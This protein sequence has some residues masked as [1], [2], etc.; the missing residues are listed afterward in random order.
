MRYK[1]RFEVKTAWG[2][3]NCHARLDIG[4]AP[5]G[6]QKYC[7]VAAWRSTPWGPRNAATLATQPNSRTSSSWYSLIVSSQISYDPSAIL[8]VVRPQWLVDSKIWFP[9]LRLRL[10]GSQRVNSHKLC[11]EDAA[12]LYP[13]PANRYSSLL[14][15]EGDDPT[16]NASTLSQKGI[17]YHPSILRV[18]AAH[19]LTYPVAY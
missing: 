5:V 10:L 16:I 4:Q 19:F 14:I 11:N 18:S 6:P 7:G 12:C 9:P 1:A 8:Q 13:R 17:S 15:L 3:R 2:V